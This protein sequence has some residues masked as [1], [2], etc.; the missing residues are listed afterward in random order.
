MEARTGAT[1]KRRATTASREAMRFMVDAGRLCS[2]NEE[3]VEVG[4]AS[5]VGGGWLCG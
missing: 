1:V 3:Q 4:K 2:E 5:V